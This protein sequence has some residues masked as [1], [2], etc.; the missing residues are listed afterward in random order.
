MEQKKSRYEVIAIGGSWGGMDALI[1][2]LK[3]IDTNFFLPVIVVLHRHKFTE[4]S[5]S[6]ILRKYLKLE[7][8][9]INEKEK[10]CGGIVYLAPRNYHVLIESDRTFSLD[11][12]EMVNYARPSIDVLFQSV[13]L[14]YA[15]KAIGILLTGANSDGSQGLKEISRRGGLTIVQDPEDAESQSMPLS[16]LQ[17]MKPDYIF[18]QENINIFLKNLIKEV[19]D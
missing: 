18:S 3:D 6:E 13:A 17:I 9:E 11:A 12:S 14:I 2:I 1:R 5:L 7:I 15:E 8:K 4:S 16:A 10:I 19:H